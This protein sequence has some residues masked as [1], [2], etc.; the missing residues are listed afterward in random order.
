MSSVTPIRLCAYLAELAFVA[1]AFWLIGFACVTAVAL[2]A[3]EPITSCQ[4]DSE[5]AALPECSRDPTCDGGPAVVGY[6][7]ASGEK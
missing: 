5:C 3:P 6:R 4:T 1:G 7:V 2:I